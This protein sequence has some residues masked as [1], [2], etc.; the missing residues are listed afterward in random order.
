MTQLISATD[1]L[2]EVWSRISQNLRDSLNERLYSTWISPVRLLSLTNETVVFGV[3]DSFYGEWLTGRY[4]PL[5]ISAISSVS[6]FTPSLSFEVFSESNQNLGAVRDPSLTSH[7]T[8]SPSIPKP[9][10]FKPL[11]GDRGGF[12]TKYIFDDFVVGPGNQFAHAAAQAVS[13]FPGKNYNPLFIYG[14]VGLGKTHLMHSIA[15]RAKELRP[16]STVCYISSEKFTN[17]LI[18]A[19]QKRSTQQFRAKYRSVDL[20]LIDDVHFIAGKDS[21]QEEFFNTFN[22][23]YDAHKQIV[24]ISD[25][26]PKDIPGLEER[27][28]SRFSWGLVTDIQPPEFETRVA[29]LLKKLEKS[30]CT[31]PLNVIHFIAERIRSNIRELE[32]SLLRLIA[33]SQLIGSSVNISLAETILK[34]SIKEEKSKVTI[35]SI[36]RAVAEEFGLRVSDLRNQSRSKS[37]SIPRQI[38]VYLVREH[39]SHSL[40]EIG[41]YFGGRNHATVLHSITKVKERLL[42]DENVRK[43]VDKITKILLSDSH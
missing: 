40:N 31:V 14:S 32:G 34:D 24:A 26:P 12:N 4:G 9:S 10:A 2:S 18:T 23:L 28:V 16:S 29:I 27:L 3:P 36:Q 39:T 25:R 13:E 15:S 35:D 1:D 20:L 33:H 43:N 7:P 42:T 8:P 41:D 17:E 19:I 22:T 6:G 11:S 38:A 21:T 30:T 37:V 5:L